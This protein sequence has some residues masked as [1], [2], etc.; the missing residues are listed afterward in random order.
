LGFPG[1]GGPV[2]KLLPWTIDYCHYLIMVRSGPREPVIWDKGGSTNTISVRQKNLGDIFATDYVKIRGL[3]IRSQFF[4]SLLSRFRGKKRRFFKKGKRIQKKRFFND[5]HEFQDN[6]F[7]DILHDFFHEFNKTKQKIS[8]LPSKVYLFINEYNSGFFKF[9]DWAG[10]V[11][12]HIDNLH[13]LA[14]DHID[15]C[16]PAV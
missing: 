3:I 2:K 7:H 9:L 12:I 4:K 8:V 1:V 5:F 14:T 16:C 6:T 11:Q 15:K 10:A 13:C